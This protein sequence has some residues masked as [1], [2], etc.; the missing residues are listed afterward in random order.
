MNAT[1]PV[2]MLSTAP[3]ILNNPSPFSDF[4]W[5]SRQW[6]SP[7]DSDGDLEI[8]QVHTC[9]GHGVGD[10]V[11]VRNVVEIEGF[12]RCAGSKAEGVV[13]V[14]REAEGDAQ[15]AHQYVANFH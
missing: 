3:T 10:L 1:S 7:L 6:K 4:P 14:R 13:L 11:L 8:L 5:I 9:L 2:G 12:T 15:V